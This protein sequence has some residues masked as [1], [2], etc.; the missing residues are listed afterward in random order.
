MVTTFPLS[1]PLFPLLLSIFFF[2]SIPFFFQILLLSYTLLPQ[3][4]ICPFLSN[5]LS[6][7]L[8]PP[9]LPT[10]LSSLFSID[11]NITICGL[12]FLFP[13][14]H[15]FPFL[16]Y[17]SL[18]SSLHDPS[19]SKI[20]IYFPIFS[21]HVPLPLLLL[22][23]NT[24]PLFSLFSKILSNPF[25]LLPFSFAPTFPNSKLLP[26]LHLL[27]PKLPPS[28]FHPPLHFLL[29]PHGLEPI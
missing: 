24:L 28:P 25:F 29:C 26:L 22:L 6:Q 20:K 9:I 16:L 10:P 13:C 21:L 4:T 2:P 7:I 5:L 19:S 8:L 27:L 17:T 3:T 18:P 1:S 12:S 11:H 15:N 23:Q 14:I